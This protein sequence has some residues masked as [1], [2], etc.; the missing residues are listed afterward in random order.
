MDPT[1]DPITGGVLDDHVYKV[2]AASAFALMIVG[3]VAYRLFEDWS[4][5]DSVYFSVVAVTTVGFGDLTPSTDA[6]KIF[7]VFYVLAGVSIITTYLHARL[8][9]RR[10]D[11]FQS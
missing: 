11:R 8:N 10:S 7:T 3:T 4:W 2:L 1:N 6:S 5:V 9:R